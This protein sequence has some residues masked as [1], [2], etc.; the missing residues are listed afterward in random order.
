MVLFRSFISIRLILF[1]DGIVDTKLGLGNY[2][3]T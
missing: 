3:Q 1:L 2:F